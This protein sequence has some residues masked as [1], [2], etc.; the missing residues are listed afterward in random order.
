[1]VVQPKRVMDGEHQPQRRFGPL[2]TQVRFIRSQKVE[3]MMGK[4]FNMGAQSPDAPM[5]DASRVWISYDDPCHRTPFTASIGRALRVMFPPLHGE[6][7]PP[8]IAQALAALAGG[9]SRPHDTV[10]KVPFIET[11]VR[12]CRLGGRDMD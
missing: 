8:Q 11:R 3:H 2:S 4:A 10:L 5:I 12:S 9:L 6:D 7:L 1:M